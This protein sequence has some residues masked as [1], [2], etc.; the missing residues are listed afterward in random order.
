MN[1]DYNLVDYFQYWEKETP[2]SEFLLEPVNRTYQIFTWGKAGNEIR[3]MAAYLHSLGLPEKSHIAIL[4]K[5]SAHWIMAD[6]AVMMAGFVSVPLYPNLTADQLKAILVHSESRFLFLGKLDNFEELKPGIPENLSCIT[7]PFYP[8][9][10][11]VTWDEVIQDHDPGDFP[12]SANEDLCCILYTSGTTGT[13]KGVMHTFGNVAFALKGIREVV[14]FDRETF[15]SYLPLCHVAEKIVVE[16]GSL[17]CGG[18][19]YFAES[20]ETFSKDL[21]FTRPTIFLAV[22]RIWTKFQ[23]SILAKIPQQRLNI[24]LSIPVV[25]AIIKRTIKKKLGLSRARVIFTGAAPITVG[26]LDWFEK[27]DIKIQEAYGMTENFSYS[28]YS[29]PHNIRKGSVGQPLPRCE[30]KLSEIGEVL[31][32]SQATMKGY[33]KDPEETNKVIEDGYLKTGDEGRIDEEGFLFITG[34]TKDI[35]KTSKGKYIAPAPIEKLIMENEMVSQTCVVGTGLPQPIALI[36]TTIKDTSVKR[37]LIIDHFSGLLTRVNENLASHEKLKK[38]ILLHKEWTVR[39]ILTPSL[40]IKRRNVETVY[41]E[42]FL[43]WYES[44]DHVIFG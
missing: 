11:Y 10:G 6:I 37:E 34:R 3:R 44:Q 35:F 21:A 36:T 13:P 30:I 28:H 42:H 5:N 18:K 31:V 27:L 2:E 40:K 14:D 25:N 43:S 29:R 38:L 22:P 8:H 41:G 4:G 24:L 33:F 9:E 17:L 12:K 1:D 15:F 19:V 26:L 23:E 7:F 20:L 16:C 39:D 32:K